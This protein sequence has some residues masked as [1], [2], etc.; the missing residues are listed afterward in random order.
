MCY[1][2]ETFQN[3]RLKQCKLDPVHFYT[4][5]GSAW[6]VPL[7]TTEYIFCEY[8]AR[9][10]DCEL[11]L[12]SFLETDTLLMFEKGIQGRGDDPKPADTWVCMGKC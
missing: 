3:L 4:A 6:Q 7:K 10:E 12:V 1:V 11:F 9:V 8:E 5:S 2:F